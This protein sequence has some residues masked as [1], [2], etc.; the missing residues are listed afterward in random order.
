MDLIEKA[1]SAPEFRKAILEQIASKF[2]AVLGLTLRRLERALAMAAL[3]ELF[4][5]TSHPPRASSAKRERSTTKRDNLHVSNVLWEDGLLMLEQ[6][7]QVSALFVLLVT[8][9]AQ[10]LVYLVNLVTF[11]I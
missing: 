10:R 11:Q 5:L 1:Q 6:L 8:I 2:L 7:H 3:W 4:L 9:Q